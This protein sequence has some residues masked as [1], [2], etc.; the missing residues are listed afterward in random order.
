MICDNCGKEISRKA[1]FCSG[2][3]KEIT[4][5]EIT[6]YI[7][8]KKAGF[9]RFKLNNGEYLC[10]DCFQKVK[11]GREFK[12]KVLLNSSREEI[13][14]R[15]KVVEEQKRIKNA[16]KEK[17][18][19]EK[20]KIKQEKRNEKLEKKQQKEQ[21]IIKRKIEKGIDPYF[22]PTEKHGKLWFNDHQK[23]AVIPKGLTGSDVYEKDKIQYSDIISFELLEDGASRAH[24]GLGKAL[25]G[26]FFLGGLGA[27]VGATSKKVDG[28]C[29]RLEIKLTTK[30]D[31][32]FVQY[33][34][35]E[36][37]KKSLKYDKAFR[38]AQEALSKLQ[39]ITEEIEGKKEDKPVEIHID[40]SNLP[41]S[42]NLSVADELKK[43]KELLDE[44]II[45]QEEFNNQK[46]K[47]LN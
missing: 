43:L 1:K 34:N 20:V 36:C 14:E 32:Y 33:I 40:S 3:G 31:T 29:T 13:L 47:L 12:T 6:C 17:N 28:T 26:G 5:K 10:P 45:T 24:G 27:T 35:W 21:E 30:K 23:I 2:C 37:D 46:A 41:T 38:R 18:N 19:A 4:K 44:G 39:R 9:G 8:G 25:V 16:E 22:E 11:T 42:S 7:C 15:I